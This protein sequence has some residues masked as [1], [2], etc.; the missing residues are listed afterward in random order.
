MVKYE[1]TCPLAT[2]TWLLSLILDHQAMIWDQHASILHQEP[3]YTWAFP[4]DCPNCC[5]SSNLLQCED[6]QEHIHRQVQEQKLLWHCECCPWYVRP[7]V[8]LAWFGAV[9]VWLLWL[10]E[11]GKYGTKDHTLHSTWC[12]VKAGRVKW[13]TS[14]DHEFT[15]P[16]E[17]TTRE[18]SLILLKPKERS[19]FYYGGQSMRQLV[20]NFLERYMLGWT[21]KQS[22]LWQDSVFTVHL[23]SNQDTLTKTQ[24]SWLK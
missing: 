2:K 23:G 1:I 5:S 19:G 21:M 17:F 4:L 8:H 12:H 6:D 9:L 24:E 15:S 22:V 14:R 20:C 18:P 16:H 7:W 10:D 13:S 3:S 11:K